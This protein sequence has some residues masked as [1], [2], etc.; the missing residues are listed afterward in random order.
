MT[1]Y[2]ILRKSKKYNVGNSI[3]F[4]WVMLMT[5]QIFRTTSNRSTF[6]L[7]VK[8][9][10][11][12]F[13]SWSVFKI[14]LPI[15]SKNVLLHFMFASYMILQLLIKES[16]LNATNIIAYC[17]PVLFSYLFLVHAYKYKLPKGSYIKFLNLIIITVVVMVAYSL[18]FNF[19]QFINALAVSSAYGNELSSFFT[20]NHE[21]ALY[22]LIGIQSCILCYQFLSD[23]GNKRRLLYLFFAG[24]FLVNLIM[25][26]SRTA[27]LGIAIMVIVYIFMSKNNKTKRLMI[28]GVFLAIILIILSTDLRSFAFN[29]V[30]KENN[31]AGR[32]VMWNYG[33][34]LF[35]DSSF[36]EKITGHGYSNITRLLVAY[37]EHASFHNA[38]IQVLLQ[39]GV[40]GLIFFLGIIFSSVKNGIKI[41]HRNHF[42]GSMFLSITIAAAAYMSTNTTMIMQSN[43]DSYMLTIFVIVLPIYVKNAIYAGDV[44]E[45]N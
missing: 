21:Y 15:P 30:M 29:T 37:S 12:L 18:V 17:F 13:I 41:L 6:D 34:S 9:G 33:I 38:Y 5:W 40:V 28:I 22:L 23:K 43:I 44:D 39:Y 36:L 35:R 1:N 8:I 7:L 2:P 14:H 24:L 42:M 45:W 31:D 11:I 27:L 3:F 26:Y 16:T 4:Y 25:T 19:D 32:L 20:S 10:L